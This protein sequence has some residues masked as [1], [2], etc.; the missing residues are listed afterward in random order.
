MVKTKKLQG[1][2]LKDLDDAVIHNAEA[3]WCIYD[4]GYNVVVH[5]IFYGALIPKDYFFLNPQKLKTSWYEEELEEKRV[6]THNVANTQELYEDKSGHKTRTLR[7][8]CSEKE[9]WVDDK[10]LDIFDLDL[11]SFKAD[12]KLEI[13]FVY[14]PLGTMIGFVMAVKGVEK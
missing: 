6:N 8:F 3:S 9:I 2:I 10:H 12:K 11:C 13:L 1:I 14:N 5:N 7:R 4:T